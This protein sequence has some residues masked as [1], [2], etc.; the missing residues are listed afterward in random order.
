MALLAQAGEFA[1][2][3]G[4]AA[5][6]VAVTGVGF[7]PKVVLFFW[8][9]TLGS[10]TVVTIVSRDGKNGCGNMVSL[11]DRGG[12][13]SQSDHG[14]GTSA[15]DHQVFDD[16]CI[17][18][19]DT[20]GAVDGAADFSSLDADGFTVVIDDAFSQ[21]YR[22][23]YLAIGGSDLTNVVG[24]SVTAQ[25]GGGIHDINVGLDLDT[26]LDDK[27]VLFMGAGS[28][29]PTA[30]DVSAVDSQFSFGAAAEDVPVSVVLSGAS[31]D[32]QGTSLTK[33][34]CLRG[35]CVGTDLAGSVSVNARASVSAWSATGFSLIWTEVTGLPKMRILTL[36]GGRYRL[37]TGLTSTTLNEFVDLFGRVKPVA[38]LFASAGKAEST[39][40]ATDTND[41]RYIGVAAISTAGVQSHFA[42]SYHDVSALDTTIV[43]QVRDDTNLYSNVSTAGAFDGKLQI[44]DWDGVRVRLKQTDADPANG[45][46]WAVVMGNTAGTVGAVPT[47]IDV[48]MY[49][50]TEPT[51]SLT[52][53]TA[54]WKADVITGLSDG[55]AVASWADSSGNGHTLVQSTGSLKPT[56]VA[57]SRYMNNYP[58]V[59]FDGIDDYMTRATAMSAFFGA[60]GERTVY[61]VCRPREDAYHT[62]YLWRDSNNVL[63]VHLLPTN[64]QIV[65][66]DYDGASK[67]ITSTITQDVVHLFMHTKH[68]NSGGTPL[69][70][71]AGIDDVDDADLAT[72]AAGADT[73]LT[74]SLFIGGHSSGTSTFRGEIA[75]IIVYSVKHTEAERQLIAIYLQNKYNAEEWNITA[76]TIASSWTSVYSY[77]ALGQPIS[78]SYGMGGGDL[79]RV[80]AAG[81]MTF[82][83][84]NF[85]SSNN[86]GYWAP[87]H[88]RARYG[89]DIGILC[90]LKIV[91]DGLTYYKFR[92]SIVNIAPLPGKVEHLVHV[93]VN[94]WMDEAARTK[95]RNLTVQS[96]VRS[97]QVFALLFA[98]VNRAPQSTQYNITSDLYATALDNTQDEGTTILTELKKLTD[99]ELGFCY[100]RRNQTDG[101]TLVFESRNERISKLTNALILDDT[102]LRGLDALRS[103]DEVVNHFKVEVHPRQIDTAATTVLFTLGSPQLFY[104][105]GAFPP[106]FIGT[107]RDPSQPEVRIGGTEI[108]AP[109]AGTDYTFNTAAAGTGQNIVTQL[110]VTATAYGNQVLLEVYNRGPLDGYLTSLQVR[111]KGVYAFRTIVQE[112][113]DS[114]SIAA[115]GETVVTV[116]MPYQSD[117]NVGL[118]TAYYLLN[119]GI[120]QAQKVNSAS[121]HA[122]SSPDL[123]NSALAL[124]PGDRIGLEEATT[125]IIKSDEPKGFFIAGVQFSMMAPGSIQ[126]T[127]TLMPADNDKL[128]ILEKRGYSELNATTR[129]GFA[130][131]TG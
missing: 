95:V 60:S 74:G 123:L 40:N 14:V 77:V 4:A 61:F 109:V 83:L 56:Y 15:S 85:D 103:R 91:Y 29:T 11:T 72:V 26:G 48:Q 41:E 51:P 113:S 117:P 8:N 101:E 19:L 79:D 122:N 82:A 104:A 31:I 100:I 131:F 33:T 3:T 49:L 68:P 87:N 10:D 120:R 88:P 81:S 125:G 112:A 16:A 93:V 5:S 111:G 7:T 53:M 39:K 63:E 18:L 97:D 92:G 73:D 108:V 37:K 121:Y 118:D 114:A 66:A 1:I 86:V 106:G 17:K 80:A 102:T 76:P 128:W 9:G 12:V 21:S 99:S 65:T 75:E 27:L 107:Y 35:E 28:G 34:Y 129:F 84:R 96:N 67:T 50:P 58:T 42:Q 71:F 32:A 43:Y 44:T 20:T 52:N 24:Q 25:V 54:W 105:S 45:F 6:T 69:D 94:D 124:E 46:Y 47:S 127:Y 98:N 64:H 78:F 115:N 55:D 13:T 2:G 90:R 22:I 89:F 36:L 70:V 23:A 130:I 30:L 116:D 57:K 62:G 38:T 110:S 59:E 126:V 119:R